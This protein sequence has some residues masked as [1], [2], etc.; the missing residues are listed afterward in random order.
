MSTVALAFMVNKITGSMLHMGGVMAI[1]TLP[2]V[3]TSW[4]GGALLD[5]YSSKHLMI[6]ADVAR[7]ILIAAMPFLAVRWVGLI[8]L[9]AGLVGV[10]SALFNPAQIKLVGDLAAKGNLV[11]TNSY[12]SMSRDS[13][14]LIG[15][16]VG[17]V[18]VSAVGYMPTFVADGATY[19]LSALLLIGLPQ[20]SKRSGSNPTV[21]ALIADSPA[22][23]L[24][25]W[26]HPALR[27]NLLL[28][29][30]ATTAVMLYSPNSYGLVLEVF[31]GGAMELGVMELVIA[32]GLIGGGLIMSRMSLLRDKNRYVLISL[33][34]LGFCLLGVYFSSLLWLSVVLLGLG[35]L[36][37]V[38][39][40]IPSI[41]MFQE[42]CVDDEKGR[43]ISL[44]A[45]FGQLGVASGFLLGGLLG[46]A[47][48]IR[49][50][51]GVAGGAAIILGLVIYVPYRLGARRRAEA[52]F[53]E[54]VVT[55]ERR[56]VARKA[57]ADAALGGRHGN[58]AVPDVH[59]E[60]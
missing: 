6:S 13:A 37:N 30:F 36:A 47:I 18:V 58:W 31:G 14:D 29:V 26:R 12:V 1:A 52:V 43:L 44:R 41:T 25:L 59:M 57:A 53:H 54:A 51:F 3:L 4:I 10:F 24:R 56:A 38:G 7:A 15:Y 40:T 9:I 22:V 5:R 20:P 42:V 49:E 11:R 46:D 60:E 45:G 2:V 28:A 35:G 21:V 32:C 19:L 17:G 8:Y 23:F 27:T 33:V 34:V 50:T 48:G 39:L 16:L 55:G